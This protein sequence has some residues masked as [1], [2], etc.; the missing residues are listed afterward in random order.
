M[1][2]KIALLLSILLIFTMITACGSDKG[3]ESKQDGATQNQKTLTAE[4]IMG[5]CLEKAKNADSMDS[6]QVVR[7]CEVLCLQ[8]QENLQGMYI[9]QIDEEP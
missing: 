2:K 7:L 9:L 8:L 6:G 4:E 1:K 3:S 5:K